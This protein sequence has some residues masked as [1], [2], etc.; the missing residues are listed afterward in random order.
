MKPSE[1]IKHVV[2]IVK[3]NHTFDN[4]FGRFPGADGDLH[5]QQAS[6][7]P[8][9]DPPHGHEAWLE[10]AAKA[11]KE[12]YSRQQIP[13]YYAYAEQF[14]LC[15]AYFSEV[16]GP[17]TPNHL[18]LV[19]AASPTLDDIGPD[20]VQRKG[21]PFDLPSLP[22]A[23]ERAGLE[24]RSYGGELH[25]FKLISSLRSHPNNLSPEQFAKDASSGYLPA[26]S[27]LYAPRPLDEH[28]RNSISDG[29][30]W[31]VRQVKAVVDGGL[32]PSAAIFITWDDWGG[33]FD[34]VDPPEVERWSDGTQF[35]YGSRVG[36]LVLSPYAK[37]GYI[38]H[39]RHSHVSLLGFCEKLF[40]LPPLNFRD[41]AADDM[42]DCFDWG[43][44]PLP[45]PR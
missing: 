44:Q 30:A 35:R 43:Q 33:W 11:P 42:S 39:A 12:E 20:D 3:E 32:W 34:H 27:W 16:A 38:S 24:W 5:L 31:T 25:P 45:P 23:L 18:M 37:R 19:A 9:L 36:C 14:T 1:L 10:R 13:A 6:D 15:D 2:L 21:G 22:T 7:P 8:E 26:V 29:I 41:A 28:P 4:Y 17:S 40:A